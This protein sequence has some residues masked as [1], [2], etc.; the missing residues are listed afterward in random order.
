MPA[1]GPQGGLHFHHPFAV[2]C[3]YCHWQPFLPLLKL[4]GLDGLS[5]WERGGVV[6][7]KGRS[8]ITSASAGIAPAGKLADNLVRGSNPGSS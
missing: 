6:T 4:A 8:R 5:G 1:L 2:R 7:D 3:Y